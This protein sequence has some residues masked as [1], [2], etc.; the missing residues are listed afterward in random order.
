MMRWVWLALAIILPGGFII[1]ALGLWALHREGYRWRGVPEQ[2][3]GK[4]PYDQ[5]AAKM[6]QARAAQ[7]KEDARGD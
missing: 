6:S 4:E 1:Y 5:W 7:M 3:D 2:Y